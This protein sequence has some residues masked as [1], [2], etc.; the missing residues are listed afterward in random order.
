MHPAPLSFRFFETYYYANI[1]DRILLDTG[2]YIRRVHEWHEGRAPSLFLPPFQKFSVL[3][4]FVGFVIQDLVYEQVS[5]DTLA[6]MATDESAALWVETALK[7]HG[8]EGPSFR[9]WLLE[10]GKSLSD[11]TEDDLH[12][13]HLELQ[14]AGPMEALVDQLTEEVFYLLFGNR[15][16]LA[17]L[18]Y[19]IAGIVSRLDLDDLEIELEGLLLK[20][21]VPRR[22]SPPEWAKRA[23]FFRDRGRCTSCDSDLS[24]LVGISDAEHYDHIV[25]LAEGGINDVT[26]LQ[27]LCRVC[28]QRKGRRAIP[29]PTRYQP[30]YSR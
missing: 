19:Y 28:N 11:A 8:L 12:D 10:A 6:V 3:H 21:G 14:L 20:D 15:Q 26:N 25:P 2:S 7:Y 23:V 29:T 27:L 18:H 5:V 30:W 22:A 4:D 9:Q 1:I 13:Y 24:G 17:R 16:L